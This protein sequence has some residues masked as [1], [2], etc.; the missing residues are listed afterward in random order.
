MAGLVPA[1]QA[2]TAGR[3]CYSKTAFHLLAASIGERIAFVN[4]EPSARR[5]RR[6]RS[7]H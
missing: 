6:S 3:S 1:I 4:D 7:D 5:R 2:P